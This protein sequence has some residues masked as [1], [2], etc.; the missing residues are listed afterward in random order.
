MW[1]KMGPVWLLKPPPPP[2]IQ[3]NPILCFC[4]I[5]EYY[6][7]HELVKDTAW[8]EGDVCCVQAS[9]EFEERCERALVSIYPHCISV[10]IMYRTMWK[11]PGKTKYI[12]SLYLRIYYVLGGDTCYSAVVTP[13]HPQKPLSFSQSLKSTCADTFLW[14]KLM[15]AP[16]KPLVISVF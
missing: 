16:S 14:W 7:C 10:Y 5:S 4:S 3:S 15:Y 12:S 13:A 2:C 1:T 11:S 6:S 8:S 9:A